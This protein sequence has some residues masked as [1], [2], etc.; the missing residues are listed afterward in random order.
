MGISRD[1]H[2][3]SIMM[4]NGLDLHSADI[5]CYSEMGFFGF[6]LVFL[7]ICSF[8][9]FFVVLGVFWFWGSFMVG[10]FVC[11]FFYYSPVW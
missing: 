9:G 1:C 4:N 3:F 6:L 11:L 5:C 10:W 2:D 7:V 8:L